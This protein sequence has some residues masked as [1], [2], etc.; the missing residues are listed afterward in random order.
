MQR[1]VCM[2]CGRTPPLDAKKCHPCNNSALYPRYCTGESRVV[3]YFSALE[4]EGLW[5]SV[6]PFEKRSAATLATKIKSAMD[7][8]RHSCEAG[9]HCPLV[10]EL[11]K[12]LCERLGKLLAKARGLCLNCTKMGKEWNQSSCECA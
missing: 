2:E 9:P 3:E 7:N 4:K 8:L 5:P 6:K 1:Q 10:R 12:G 11:I